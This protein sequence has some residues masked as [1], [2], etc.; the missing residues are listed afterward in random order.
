MNLLTTFWRRSL[1][2]RVT[3]FTLAIFLISIWSLAFYT[4]LMLR[5]DMVRLLGEQQYSTVS[6]IAKGINGELDDRFGALERVAETMTPAMRGNTA[7]LQSILEQRSFFQSYF[8]GG[9]FVTRLD[10]IATASIP[11]SAERAGVNFMDRDYITAALM[12]GKAT[13]S[14]PVIG[15]TTLMPGFVMTVPIRDTQ[16][17]VIGALAGVT[18]LSKPNFLDAITNGSYGKSGGYLL[19]AP[20]HNV[21]ITASDKSR[22]MRPLPAAGSNPLHDKYAKGYEGYGVLLNFRGEEELTA[23]KGIPAAG[24]FMGVAVPTAE[25]F[26][27]IYAMQQRMLLAAICLTLLAGGLTWWMLRRQLSPMLA[28]VK[29]LTT[30]SDS[31]QPAQPLP[32][33]SHDEIGQLIAGFN[34][35][36]ETLGQREE[37]L[38]ESEARL[39]CLTEMSS[40]FYW[41]SDVQH[42]FTL[43]TESVWE[44]ADPVFSGE[45][46]IGVRRWEVPC[47]SPDEAGWRAHRAL[48]DAHVPFR[49]FEI[50]RQDAHGGVHYVCV[51]GDPVF[52]AVGTFTGYCGIGTDITARKAA[53]AEIMLLA[54]YDPL[55]QLPNRR[56]L[57]DR[58]RIA[59]A[60]GARSRCHGALFFI[61]LDHFKV[62]NDT[63]GHGMGDQL[64]QQVAQRL[65]VCLREGDTVARLGGDEFVVML[66]GLSE[67]R[68]EAATQTKTVGEKI[69][70]TLSQPYLLAGYDIRSTPSM[71]I[72]LF[73]G[74]QTAI[75]ELLKQADLAMYQAK[76]VGRNTLR[77]FDPEM[78]AVATH[79][80]T[81]EADLREAL[82][83]QQFILYYQPQVAGDGRL[84]GAEALVRWLHPQRGLVSPAAF[85]P[86]AEETGLILPL[87]HWV[88]ETACAQLATW[89]VQPDTT[90]LTLAVNVS[91]SQLHQADFVDQVLAVLARTGANPH[92][93]KLELTES[94][95]VSHVEKTIV[96]MTALKA[97]GVGFSLDDF[98]T[99]YSSLSYLKRLPL[100]QLKIDQSFIKDILIDPNDAAIARMVIVLAESLGLPVI[101]EG[102]ETEAQRDFLANLGCHAYQGYLFGRPLPLD[103]FEAFVSKSITSASSRPAGTS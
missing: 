12:Q 63:L 60:S 68:E 57:Q 73:S 3:L 87:G 30:L 76:A 67:N 21:F 2:T 17:K 46:F 82:R 25:A 9:A 37:A 95:L 49:E 80:A 40:D 90:D 96:K 27:P 5:E 62:L 38:R 50:S 36:L 32:I 81:M 55:T 74:H 11:L 85:I 19:A 35:L 58:L 88:L 31:D 72:T 97:H 28:V 43:R 86:L 92:R 77:F 100:D 65:V 26:A 39:R 14:R 102:V 16:G 84:T 56:L 53:E 52:D 10:G 29:T 79:H 7:A 33:S 42:R 54:F 66:E 47:L 103:E 94:L 1:K 34:R 93:L 22:I 51:S 20:Q 70:A 23:A 64:L 83:Q 41:D 8:N 91:A 6:L 75:E 69:L 15:K 48:L 59:M 99:G 101:G 98:G 61:D 71:G 18:H 89:A 78:Q 4:S 13:I 44:A 24:W 45:S